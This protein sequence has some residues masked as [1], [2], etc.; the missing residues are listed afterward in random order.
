MQA[1]RSWAARSRQQKD[2]TRPAMQTLPPLTGS[3][4]PPGAG[5]CPPL[6]LTLLPLLL[7]LLLLLLALCI[8]CRPLGRALPPTASV[9]S[10]L[11]PSCPHPAG[12]QT[13][14]VEK[15]VGQWLERGADRVGS[16]QS[17]ANSEA[18]KH[19]STPPQQSHPAI[20]Q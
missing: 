2:A 11:G 18:Q 12:Q 4:A 7:L 14:G 17:Y 9:G 3:C 15:K 8:L 6:P 20:Y 5:C 10:G 19:R 1:G 13:I 16:A